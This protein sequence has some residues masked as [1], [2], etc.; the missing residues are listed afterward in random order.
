MASN[1]QAVIP[2]NIIKVVGDIPGG[3]I[4][5]NGGLGKDGEG[6][7]YVKTD[8]ETVGINS[9]GELEVIGGVHEYTAGTGI[10]ITNDE[11]SVDTSV[12]ATQTDLESY[13]PTASLATVAV[14]GDYADLL[15]TPNL[16]LKEDVANKAQTVDATSTTDYPS[17]AG[18]AQYVS[19]AVA[20]ATATFLGN[21]TLT[22]L[23]LTYPA[24]EQQITAALA[25]HT[26]PAGTTVDNNDYVYVE[27]QNPQTTGVDDS[28]QRYKYN[29]TVW[30]YEYTLNNSSFTP[31]EVAALESGVNSTKVGNYDAH[32]VDTAIHVTSSD[33]STWNAKQDAI[34]DLETI[35]TGA[36]LGATAVQPAALSG[37]QEKLTAGSNISISA[38][39]EISATDTTYSA[40]NGLALNGTTFSVDTSV[41]QPKLTAGANVQI[42]ANNEISATDTTY[43]AGANVQI[44]GT[45]ISATDTTYTAG[46]GLV[47]SGTEFSADTSVLQ[48]KLTAGSNISISANNEISATGTLPASTSADEGKFLLVDANGLP[49]WSDLSD[50]SSYSIARGSVVF[51]PG[52][53][54]TD[55]AVTLSN[56]RSN[57]VD[58]AYNHDGWVLERDHTYVIAFNIVASVGYAEPGN[59]TGRIWLDGFQETDQVWKFSLDT[60]VSHDESLVGSAI[61]CPQSTGEVHL[62]I[63]YDSPA[64]AH[65]PSAS[66]NKAEIVDVTARVSG[67]G[68]TT[69]SAGTGLNL[70]GTTFSVD[71][72]TIATTSAMQTA[73]ASKQDS[74]VAGDGISIDGNNEISVAVDNST[75]TVNASGE[76]QANIPAPVQENFIAVYGTTTF[77]EIQSAY[78]GGK[79]VFLKYPET[80]SVGTGGQLIPVSAILESNSPEYSYAYFTVTPRGANA[81]NYNRC[82]WTTYR[83]TGTNVWDSISNAALPY[84]DTAG[85]V[86]T[87]TETGGVRF[88]DPVMPTVDQTYN[89]A[90]TNAQS[91]T[92]VA[93]ALATVDEVPAVTSSDDDKVL[94]ASYSGGVGSYSWEAEPTVLGI[95]AGSNVT[96]TEGVSDITIAATDTTYTSGNMISI[97]AN[98]SNAIGVSTT[99]GITDIQ[100]VNALP[101]QPVA[102]VLYIIPET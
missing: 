81:G 13:T 42:S 36:G 92:A 44:N 21:F 68:A 33:K 49:E 73:L 102:T 47:L 3:K 9:D 84:V 38:N 56:I 62:N 77:S 82:L 80:V 5:D 55:G 71:T 1:S 34:S 96:V 35:R 65:I 20:T 78:N 90:S 28:V 43:S 41:V 22:E 69:Y 25:A 54:Y 94:K 2:D 87:S 63:R 23:G 58:Y 70:T 16:A 86:L 37:Y 57:G 67:S 61:V 6:A 8:G 14:S 29:G 97:D 64:L 26:W 74:L 39:N 66:V 79:A 95:V 91:G 99:A 101:A 76:I 52:Q 48:P 88:I 17:S 24:T 18:V 75:I 4:Q 45:T 7:L 32:I 12:V 46:S 60:S 10:D 27:I 40:G 98:N 51:T 85:K 19:S 83:V 11:I 100:L 30:G 93:G 59:V 72:T 89:A 50:G 31:G 53:Y 15:N